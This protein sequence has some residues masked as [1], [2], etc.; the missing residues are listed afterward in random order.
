MRFSLAQRRRLHL[1]ACLCA[2]V[3]LTLYS[4]CARNFW[5]RQADRDANCLIQEKA[6]GPSWPLPEVRV[7]TPPAS[8]M[9]D[10]S[11]P[12]RPAMPPDDPLSHQLMHCVDG[13]KGYPR[14]HQNGDIPYVDTNC[15]RQYL[16]YNEKGEVVLD[17]DA[18]VQLAL[19]NSRTYQTEM[20][21]LY[22][23][24]LDVSFERFRFDAQ[25]FAGTGTIF[26][27][28]GPKRP[29]GGNNSSSLL[30][31]DTTGRVQKLNAFGGETVVG[32]ANSLIW[33]FSGNHSET[34]FTI[35]DFSLVQPLLRFGGRARVL[36][37]LTLSERTLLA[38]VRQIEQFRQGFY[39]EVVIGHATGDG[40]ARRVGIAGVGAAGL[41]ITG[42]PGGG[43][44]GGFVGLLQTDQQI[45]NQRFNVTGLRDSVAQ[46]RALYEAGRIPNLLQVEQ[47]RQALNSAQSS[48]LVAR[49]GYEQRL[50]A[51][52]IQL[53]LPPD[54]PIV[55]KDEYLDRFRLIDDEITTLQDEAND[56]LDT[57]RAARKESQEVAA[58]DQIDAANKLPQNPQIPN[59]KPAQVKEI[60]DEELLAM[61]EATFALRPRVEEEFT[62]A[63]TEH[64]RLTPQ[65]G[66]RREQLLA[67]RERDEVKRGDI[68]RDTFNPAALDERVERRSANLHRIATD[69]EMVWNALEGLQADVTNPA[70]A[71]DDL[72]QK[73]EL[74]LTDLS[75][76][77]L[78]LS[79]AQAGS[80]LES[81]T[82][83]EVKV[84]APQALEIARQ[85]RRDW[86]NARAALV[87]AWRRI[88]FDAN[89][90]KSDLNLT[91]SGDLQTVDDH[92]FRFRGTTGRLRVGVQFDSPLTRMVERNAYRETLINYQR[93][94]RNYMLFEDRINQSLRNIL[95]II[96]MFT[97]NF[98]M[99]RAGV[100]V[101][102]K[103]VDLAREKLREPPK[104]AA[105]V[106]LS[107]T[108]A[109]DLVSALSDLLRAQNDFLGVWVNY[110]ALRMSLDLEMGTMQLDE[111]G[112]WID[113]G[114]IDGNWGYSPDGGEEMEDEP[115]RHFE[116]PAEILP[117]GTPQL[118][119]P[120]GQELPAPVQR[121]GFEVVE[122]EESPSEA[123]GR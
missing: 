28:D 11:N 40:P 90:L 32:L 115:W 53:G 12:D 26:T 64:E 70:I 111:R 71:N 30:R 96:Q 38:N 24:A 13:K 61:I 120:D 3:M 48:L 27:A 89:A 101:A 79:L 47:A 110:E 60:S 69:L 75:G 45:R 49:A 20:E 123:V 54:L 99:S 25:F 19:L 92:P 93:A 97:L 107:P 1:L 42:S 55:I 17:R 80:R 18:A 37:Q 14:W 74:Q 33:Q 117:E 35:L 108:S 5:R 8:R 7:Y 58:Q 43:N 39:S 78:E 100:I 41:G 91:L 68:D 36:E 76:L 94:R 44:V 103:Q 51:Y 22:L 63:K 31:T 113:P 105:A 56:H 104:N 46:L 98:E 87:D 121:T 16:P 77:L 6:P 109:R 95:R 21:D 65:L 85:N 88:E 82:L 9:F 118:R 73:V 116:L 62:V 114:V 34:A 29:G 81:I 119:T 86:M 23:S 15:W 83:T 2:L 66:G 67:L 59:V 50:D 84:E 112:M 106:A 102:V 10:Q 57:V 4:G 72:R 52:K 122:A